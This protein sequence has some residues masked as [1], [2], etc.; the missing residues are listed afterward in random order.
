MHKA[1]HFAKGAIE[2]F[3]ILCLLIPEGQ[4]SLHKFISV[5]KF[6]PN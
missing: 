2:D 5:V 6:E 3:V 4:G 1:Q